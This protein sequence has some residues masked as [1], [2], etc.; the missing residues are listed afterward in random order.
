[1]QKPTRMRLLLVLLAGAAT[2]P[3]AAPPLAIGAL[4]GRAEPRT[5]VPVWDRDDLRGGRLA[6]LWTSEG[7][8]FRLRSQDARRVTVVGEFNEWDEDATPLRRRRDGLWK[9]VVDL[10]PGEWRY[11][12]VVDGEWIRDPDNP[13][14]GRDPSAVGETSVIRVDRDEITLP[15][16]Y[17]FHE[18]SFRPRASYQR[19][20][21]VTLGATLAY[22]NRVELHPVLELGGAWSF[23]QDQWLYDVGIVQ[24][25]IGEEVLDVG[26]SVYRRT[27][28][29]DA[30]RIGDF[31]NTLFALLFHEDWRDYHEAEGVSALAKF[32]AGRDVRLGVRGRNERH[33]SLAKTTNWSLFGGSGRDMRENPAVD[34]GRLRSVAAFAELDTRN[35]ER[36][37]TRGSLL[38]AQWEWAGDRLGGDF[39]FQRGVADL[40]R[41]VKLSRRHFFDIRVAGGIADQARRDG[42]DGPLVGFPA[43]P[44]Q[45]RFYL[46]GVGTMRATQFKS[47]AGDRM[48]LA[49]AET[50]VEIF[51][52][53]QA[54]V[55]VDV[56]DAY[57][58]D[59]ADLD[60]HW[61]AG[62]GLQDSDGSFRLNV[63]KK[64]DR[65]SPRDLFVSARLERM[66]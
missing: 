21:Q 39:E 25:L 33:R 40:R 20:D 9:T 34:E 59:D 37:P 48:L 41:Y 32:Y 26:L 62:I 24:P 22:E 29:P 64:L 3:V 35:S 61:D 8:L 53:F 49:N 57:V 16:P 13:V 52:D 36:N 54:A 45:E 42:P 17:G 10:A 6:P 4:S 44:V 23:G 27:D 30:F 15:R 5:S 28:T 11:L 60:L 51:E 7:V 56:G 12:F 47:L 50:R 63:A 65:G 18:G 19:V 1:L 14:V 46:G 66:F 31:E 43:I 38:R 58:A 2:L 55:F